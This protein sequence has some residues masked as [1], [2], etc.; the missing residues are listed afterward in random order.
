M[1]FGKQASTESRDESGASSD[2]KNLEAKI[3]TERPLC[4]QGPCSDSACGRRH[5][6]VASLVPTDAAPGTAVNRQEDTVQDFHTRHR[7]KRSSDDC[8]IHAS[9]RR[10]TT[11]EKKRRQGTRQHGEATQ[12]ELTTCEKSALK[13]LGTRPQVSGARWRATPV[14][15]IRQC[16]HGVHRSVRTLQEAHS[17]RGDR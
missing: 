1:D 5:E 14:P 9:R 2:E 12:Q 16:R 17:T 4:T 8:R 15:H 13:P 6:G 3:E 7:D 10:A 11:A